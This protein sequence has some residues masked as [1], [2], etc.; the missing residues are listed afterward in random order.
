M[1]YIFAVA[2]TAEV[3]W[4]GFSTIG[5]PNTSVTQSKQPEAGE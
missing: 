3:D 1:C 4:L 2:Q 5:S